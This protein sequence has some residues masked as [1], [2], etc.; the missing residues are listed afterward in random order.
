MK[1]SVK[2][3]GGIL[4]ALVVLVGVGVALLFSSLNS[5]VRAAVEQV[6]SDVTGTQVT[7]NDVDISLSEGRGTLLGFEMTN[8]SGFEADEAFRFDEVTVKLDPASVASDPIVIEEISV[9][10]PEI[11]YELAPEGSNIEAIQ[12]NVANYDT[13]S[14]S[15]SG[16][17]SGEGPKIVIRNLYLKRG[18]VHVLASRFTDET[19]TAEL[20]DIHLK[21]IG[22]EGKGATPAEAAKQVMDQLLPKLTR[23]VSKLDISAVSDAVNAGLKDAK[24][25]LKKAGESVAKELSGAGSVADDLATE[26]SKALKGLLGN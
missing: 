19:I 24:G 25:T 11:T 8:P 9:I 20:P 10:A 15:S 26:G 22:Q 21:N 3:G 2:I 4:L 7:L 16:A 12:G 6:G 23:A 1:R 5:I 14:S 17:A 13:G 18:T